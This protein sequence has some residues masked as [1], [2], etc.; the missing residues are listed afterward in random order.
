MVVQIYELQTR[1]EFPEC[2]MQ[3]VT[4]FQSH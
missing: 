4:I 1:R 2:V 3:C